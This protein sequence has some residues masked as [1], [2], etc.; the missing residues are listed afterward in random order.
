MHHPSSY[1]P[2]KITPAFQKQ[3]ETLGG[4]QDDTRRR[5][6]HE[7]A[8]RLERNIREHEKSKNLANVD[9]AQLLQKLQQEDQGVHQL[10]PDMAI[11]VRIQLKNRELMPLRLFH[12]VLPSDLVGSGGCR[13]EV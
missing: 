8:Q 7:A 9:F 11:R 10:I 6:I 4:Y 13:K 5:S 3:Q 2:L 12:A 1:I